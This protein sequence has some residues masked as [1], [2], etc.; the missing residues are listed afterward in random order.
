M[1]RFSLFLKMLFPN[2]EN[3]LNNEVLPMTFKVFMTEIS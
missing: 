1:K 3:M 2:V